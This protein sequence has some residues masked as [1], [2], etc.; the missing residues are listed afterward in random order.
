MDDF[1]EVW[2]IMTILKAVSEYE[3][4][5]GKPPPDQSHAIAETLLAMALQRKYGQSFTVLVEVTLDEQPPSTP[6]IAVFPKLQIDWLHDVERMPQPPLL[7]IEIATAG[8]TQEALIERIAKHFDFGVRS[9]WLVQ[10]PL[11]QIAVFTP[12]MQPEVFIRGPVQD[13]A[14]G[15]SVNIE[16]IFK[17]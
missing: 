6:D 17:G 3:R 15:F 14:S 11:Q 9:C 2:C 7:A 1:R 12:E 5:R 13:P 8:H 4:E 16:D 10:P